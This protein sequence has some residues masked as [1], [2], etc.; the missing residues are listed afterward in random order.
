M[1]KRLLLALVWVA[2]SAGMAWPQSPP[3]PAAAVGYN[4]MTFGS[5]VRVGTTSNPTTSFPVYTSN[6][7]A[8]YAFA[9]ASWTTVGFTTNSDG[10]VSM[11]GSGQQYGNGLSTASPGPSGGPRSTFG[12]QTFGGGFFAVARVKGTGG[13]S[14]WANDIETQNGGSQGLGT[15]PWQPTQ[16]LIDGQY[17]YGDWGELD[18]MEFDSPNVYGGAMHNWYAAAI[19]SGNSFGLNSL[20]PPGNQPCGI[21]SLNSGSSFNEPPTNCCAGADFTQYHDYGFL[22]V[23]ATGTAKG[24]AK[25]YFDGVQ[26]GNTYTWNQFNPTLNPPP[27]DLGQGGS[28]AY[29]VFDTLHWYLILGGSPGATT[30]VA[31]VQVWQAN[32]LSDLPPI[33]VAGGKTP[34]VVPVPGT[35]VPQT[36]VAYDQS[37][38]GITLACGRPFHFN[39]LPPPSYDPTDH[40]YP[41]YI[42]FHPDF[43]GD[44]WYYNGNTNPL[45]LTNDE[46]GSYN[47]GAWLKQYPAFYV[48][49]YA[50]QT[51]GNGSANSCSG[52][53]N[54]AVLNWGGWFNNGSVGSGTHYSGDTGPNTFAVIQMIQ[55]LEATYSIDPNRIYINGFSLGAIYTDYACLHYNAYNGDLGRYFAACAG[56]A[57]VNQ[58]NAPPNSTTANLMSTVPQWMFSGTG[59]GDSPPGAWNTPLCTLLGGNPSSLTAITSATANQCGSSAMRYTLC[60]SCGHQDTDANGNPVWTNTTINNF[61]FAQSATG[62]VTPPA[63]EAITVNP[64][65]TQASA[66]PFTVSGTITGL[67]TAPTLQYSV[68]GG[69]W[70]SLPTSTGTRNAYNQ[71]G[72]NVSVWNTP[73]GTGAIWTTLYHN[74]ICYIGTTTTG[75]CTGIVNPVN[76]FGITEYTST[77]SSDG[78][79]AFSGPNGRTVAPDNGATLTATMHVPSG[80]YTP[81]PYPGDNPFILQDLTSFPNRQYTWSGITG[82]VASSWNPADAG[83]AITLSNSN[84][85][86]TTNTTLETGVRSI[87]SNSSGKLYAEF[88]STSAM[89]SFWG[90]GIASSTWNFT[91]STIGSGTSSVSWSTGGTV[92]FNNASIGTAQGAT[93]SGSVISMAV[94]LGADLIWFRVNG[95]NWNNNG[96]ANPATGVGGFSIAG[97]SGGAGFTAFGDLGTTGEGVTRAGN[98]PFVE[99]VPAGFSPWDGSTTSNGVQPPGLQAGQGPFVA[100]EGGEWDDIT[101]DTYGQDYDTGLSGYN[102]GDGVINACDVNP[103]CNPFY[104]QIKHGLRYMLPVGNFASNATTTG[105]SVLLPSGWPDRVQDTQTGPNVYTGTLPFGFTL[106]IPSTTAMP[107]GLDAN[108][109]GLFWTMQHYPLIPRDA[110]AG[111]FHLSAD[112]T[113]S[114]SAYGTSINA[115]LPTLVNLLQVLT[116]Q[117]IGGQ[118]FTSSPANGPGTPSDTGP[119][120]LGT[121]ATNV[122][123]TSYFFTEPGVAAGAANTISVRDA[124]SVTTFGTSN[125]FVVTGSSGTTMG[126]I[127]SPGYV[128]TSGSQFR[129]GSG[130]N[131][132]LACTG[133]GNPTSNIASDMTLIGAQGFNCIQVPWFDKTTCAGGAC[134][135]A[136]FDTIVSSASAVG[137]RVVFIHQGNEGTNGSGSC[138]SQQANGLWYDVN[139]AAPWNATNTTDGCGTAG[140]VSYAQFKANWLQFAQHY[141][142]N[143]T[144][145]GF[146]LHNEPTTFGNPAC[147]ATAGGGGTGQFHVSG[148]YLIDP[149][150]AK[151]IE[152]GT[153]IYDEDMQVAIQNSAGFPIKN[154][155]PGINYLRIGVCGGGDCAIN[156]AGSGVS[157]QPTS[158]SYRSPS[159]YTQIAAWCQSARIVCEFEDHNSNGGYWEG[160]N[161]SLGSLASYPPQGSLLTSV[162]NFWAAMATQFKGN[163]YAW[164]GTLNE[165]GGPSYNPSDLMA[166]STYHQALYNAIRATGNS[167][168]VDFCS[169]FGCGNHGTLGPAALNA[170]VYASM[171]NVMWFIHDYG[172]YASVAAAQADLVGTTAPNQDGGP[173]CYG[174]VCAQLI[175]SADGVMP[176]IFNEWG[177]SDGAPGSTD[178]QNLAT[179]MQNVAVA[180]GAGQ[181]SYDFFNLSTNQ[182]QQV[183]NGGT[184]GLTVGPSGYNLT[185]WGGIVAAVVAANPFPGGTGSIAPQT[186]GAGWGTATG[187]DMKAMVEDVGG[188]LQTADPGVLILVEGIL[189]NGTLFNGTARGSTS[190]PITAGS[191]S[192][193]STIST[194]PVACCTARVG[195]VVHDTPTD[196]SGVLP[197]SG[198]GATTMRNTAWGYLVT[199]NIAPV[200]I[201]KLGASLDNTNGNLTDETAWATGLTQYMNGQLG[202]QGGPTFA[203]CARPISGDWFN[204]GNLAGQQ[205]DGTLNADNSN[206]A[207][208]QTYWSTLL[209]TTCTGGGGGGI[210]GTT[211][212][213]ADKS[214]AITLSNGNLTATD[215][216]TEDS[217][218]VRS[219]TG[220]SAGKVYFEVTA[221]TS[222][223]DWAAGLA[224]STFPLTLHA[225]LG[226]D[227]NGIGF[228]NVNPPQ[229]IYYNNGALATGTTAG[230]S[231][232]IIY[233]AAD[234]T[235]HL[236]WVSSPVMRAAS[237]PWNDS[238]SANPATGVGGVSFT[239][240]TCPCFITFNDEEPGAATINAGGPFNGTVPTGFV[241]FQPT[242]TSGGRIILL[243]SMN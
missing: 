206:K 112:Q 126:A 121:G 68:N 211:W 136:P 204:F 76:N 69:T 146:D 93:A 183:N 238:G 61:L 196:I 240:L 131:Q 176:V 199:G 219:T 172:S 113:A 185:T 56:S 27:V 54:D 90:V 150:G 143:T 53:G 89:A 208:Q 189:N 58:A 49:P 154:L 160:S 128:S 153:N 60:P 66:T 140:T 191:I 71:P 243:N 24:Y 155:F 63:G 203:G 102:L 5:S 169:G 144:V 162:T 241:A 18:M 105:G 139:G 166:Q 173:G 64:I 79:Y 216:A 25:W 85:T 45:F 156:G 217:D 138:L 32:G 14:F 224:N 98:A 57:G 74:A 70:L 151:F 16:P 92:F 130:N 168:M 233:F 226:G 122:T 157:G 234:L 103:T 171:T 125:S 182:F 200:W 178:G 17:T 147:C 229:Y 22:W 228:Y 114:T 218:G 52:D 133:Y 134:V 195:Y 37:F 177:S 21:N 117:H 42:W 15:N 99:A 214:A 207:G 132:R 194:R 225:G 205:P 181:G 50:D 20:S 148:G 212:N 13:Q 44:P 67:T 8:P 38:P 223:T 26:V 127:L 163:P 170:S 222:S 202:A 192:D 213:P 35:V 77:L 48:A 31:S 41:L 242:V 23:P 149:T 40:I 3:A 120:P 55:F 36:W 116:N 159:F 1:M 88:T 80:A 11:D 118:P 145:I 137:L 184:T 62:G 6:N 101:S 75:P 4:T 9:G 215:T 96:S 51:N 119:L 201:G 72:S 187:G 91:S 227:G 239:G 135:F 230:A 97:F 193:L 231:G 82:T 29:S 110:A 104:P 108:C 161:L 123:P 10:S 175:Q 180:D 65:A 198:S 12:G 235:N 84:T 186:V 46:V 111:G 237:T 141:A 165:I 232:D 220:Q 43:Q 2:L 197:D 167:N 152:S 106:G 174:Y 78:T 28:S 83:T 221:T 73:F 34:P 95:G 179:A 39:V 210:G 87:V 81:G 30:T 47:T 115:C 124:N 142:G 7:W 109:Q 33:T 190:F 164:I 236:L 86:A 209:Y 158:I 188:A 100:L 94:D 19:C 59:D 129:D 107:S